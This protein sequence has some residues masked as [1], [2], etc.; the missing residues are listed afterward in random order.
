[1]DMQL[2]RAAV[3]AFPHTDWSDRRAV[4]AHR[5]RWIAARLSLGDRW[6]LAKRVARTINSDRAVLA[7]CL[8]GWPVILYDVFVWVAA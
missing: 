7:V 8:A 3:R 1:M 5:R 6:L 2:A 4:N